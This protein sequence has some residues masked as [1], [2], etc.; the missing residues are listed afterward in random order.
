MRARARAR[1]H[2]C[3]PSRTNPLV[4][5]VLQAMV[6]SNKTLAKFLDQDDVLFSDNVT[7]TNQ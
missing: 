1:V 6:R 2:P 4:V 7:K 5:P 3:A